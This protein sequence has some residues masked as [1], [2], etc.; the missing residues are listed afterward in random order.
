[1]FGGGELPDPRPPL[2]SGLMLAPIPMD[3]P[4][5]PPAARVVAGPRNRFAFTTFCPPR[6]KSSAPVRRAPDIRVLPVLEAPLPT[7][8]PPEVELLPKLPE[9]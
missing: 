5:A 8:L 2:L 7:E 9:E 4:R 6:R 3:R 1:M